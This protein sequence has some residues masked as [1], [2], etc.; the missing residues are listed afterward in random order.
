MVVPGNGKEIAKS[1]T[2][3][4]LNGDTAIASLRVTTIAILYNYKGI[5]HPYVQTRACILETMTNS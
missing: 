3:S 4:L 5:V 1:K 2:K